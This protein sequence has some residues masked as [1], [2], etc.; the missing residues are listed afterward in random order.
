[1]IGERHAVVPGSMH[2]DGLAIGHE[3]GS[4]PSYPKNNSKDS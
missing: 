3:K 2:K 4:R 1:M